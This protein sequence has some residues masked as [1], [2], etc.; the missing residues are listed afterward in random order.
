L[1]NEP[2]AG[3]ADKDC[4]AE[5]VVGYNS[6]AERWEAE[7]AGMQDIYR[8]EQAYGAFHMLLSCARELREVLN[9]KLTGPGE[10]AGFG[11][12]DG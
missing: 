2:L 1:D 11:R 7:A 5:G 8:N 10:Q 4:S 6:L 3:Q 9:A 12:E